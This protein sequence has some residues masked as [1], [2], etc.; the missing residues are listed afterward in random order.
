MRAS[1]ENGKLFALSN[2]LLVRRGLME[3]GFE[4][5]V[6][7]LAECLFD[8]AARV[9]TFTANKAFGFDS[10]LTVE[11][12]DDLDGFA[13]TAPPTLMVSFTEPSSSACSVTVWPFL[14]ASILAFST[15]YP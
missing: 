9:A 5:L 1:P 10:R 15:A 11:C 3:L 14:R 2:L 12:N 6:G 13:H 7:L 8:E 4:Q